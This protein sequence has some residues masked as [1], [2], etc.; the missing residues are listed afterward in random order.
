MLENFIKKSKNRSSSLD[1][2]INESVLELSVPIFSE[3]NET[4]SY[5]RCAIMEVETKLRVLN[6]EFSDPILSSFPFFET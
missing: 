4:M 2:L 1:S 3:F 5:Y 6:E